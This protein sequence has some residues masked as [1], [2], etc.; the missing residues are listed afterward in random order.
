MKTFLQVVP[1]Q[2]IYYVVKDKSFRPQVDQY[3]DQ[4]H[5]RI[6]FSSIKIK[7]LKQSLDF[8]GFNPTYNNYYS[9]WEYDLKI[10][11]EDFNSSLF[12]TKDRIY[13]T[14]ESQRNEVMKTM[15]LQEIKR[16]QLESEMAVITAA[17]KIKEIRKNYFSVLNEL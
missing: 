12:E 17:K 6:N 9:K 14:E 8:I 1:G 5:D 15:A 16:I 2:E 11:S 13:F 3:G 4:Y 10:H 7:E